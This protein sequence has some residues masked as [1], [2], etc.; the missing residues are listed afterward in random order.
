VMDVRTTIELT[1]RRGGRVL[2]T[3]QIAKLS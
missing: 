2:A 3:V 1:A